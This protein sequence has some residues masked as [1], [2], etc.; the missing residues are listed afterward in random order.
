[1]R[2]GAAL[3]APVLLMRGASATQ[4]DDAWTSR[5]SVEAGD[6][7]ASGR[8]LYFVLE[9]GYQ[10]VLEDGRTRLIISVLAETRQVDGVETRVVEERETSAGSLV[11][12]SRNFYALSK[13]TNAVFY[14]G[15]D[16]DVYKN[17][18][19]VGHEGGWIAGSGGAHFGLMMAGLPLLGARYYEEYAPGRAMDRARIVS[20]SARVTTPGG[21]FAN[22][23]DVEETTPL[24]PN[25]REHKRYAAGV[26]LVQDGALKLVRYGAAGAPSR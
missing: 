5:F 15:E 26:G 3:L 16:V 2:R 25:Q 12:V 17:G 14:F 18:K 1:M 4:A 8:N 23:V 13:R 6:L 9:P 19:V 24:E 11:E 20:V 10:L 21:S 22:V 7:T